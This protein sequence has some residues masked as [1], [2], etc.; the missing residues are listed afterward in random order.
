[1]GDIIYI[2][3]KDGTVRGFSSGDGTGTIVYSLSREADEH[4][5]IPFRIGSIF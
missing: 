4:V 1:M 5:P 2:L 3:D